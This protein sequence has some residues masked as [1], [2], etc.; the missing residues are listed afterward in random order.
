MPTTSIAVVAHPTTDG[1]YRQK[2]TAG[3]LLNAPAEATSATKM[4]VRTVK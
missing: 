3:F 2:G 4:F 1:R